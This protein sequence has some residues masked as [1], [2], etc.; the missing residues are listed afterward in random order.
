ACGPVHQIA[1]LPRRKQPVVSREGAAR[2]PGRDGASG[3]PVG[4]YA[5]SDAGQAGV[6][7]LEAIGEL[8]VV[9]AEELEHGRLEVVYMDRV[10]RDGPAD[11]VVLAIGHPATQ[12]AACHQ[13]CEGGRMMVAPCDL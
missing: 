10:L 4:D 13:V 9:Q 3:D 12:S 8:E 6:Q 11:L 1:K 7:T 2:V 5:A